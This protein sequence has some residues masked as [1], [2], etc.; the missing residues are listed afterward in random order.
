[1]SKIKLLRKH[2]TKRYVEMEPE[3]SKVHSVMILACS[4]LLYYEVI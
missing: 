2:C 3:Y 4:R 1:M